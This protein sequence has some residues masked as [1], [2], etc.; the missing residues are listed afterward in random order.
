MKTNVY[1]AFFSPTGTTNSITCEVARSLADAAGANLRIIDFT[2]AGQRPANLVCTADDV[3]VF[4]FPVYAGR[5][6]ELLL[7]KIA[8]FSGDNTPAVIVGLYGN[9][10][11]EDALV[12]AAD[13]LTE[14]GFAVVAASAF[15]GEHS[16][17][18]RVATGRPDAGDV[19]LAGQF[20][21]DIAAR[22]A[23]GLPDAPTIPGNR[24]YKDRPAPADIRPQ[25]T[26][27]CTACGICVE[28]CP[29]GII[30][31]DDPTKVE[32]G[33]IRCNAC[34]KSC[35]EDA[36]YFDNEMTNKIV[37]MLETKFAD[38]KEPELFQ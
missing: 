5:V 31:A 29:L 27:D 12:E 24:P 7:E 19:A 28:R 25:T 38:R 3:L 26:D 37:T 18:A 32:V 11:F 22:L 13:L 6:P 10:A 33:C 8:R 23:T 17:T 35:P 4:G 9:R 2:P 15:I 36:K 21:R 30:D 14:Q 34:V 1:A 16:M 20:G